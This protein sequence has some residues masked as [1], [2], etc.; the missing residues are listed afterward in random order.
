MYFNFDLEK[1]LPGLIIITLFSIM[2]IWKTIEVII[3]LINHVRF[4]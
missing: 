3:W 4:I 1:L 2:G